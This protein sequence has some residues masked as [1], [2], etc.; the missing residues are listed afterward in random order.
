MTDQQPTSNVTVASLA[1][2]YQVSAGKPHFPLNT[3]RLVY[4][5]FMETIAVADPAIVEKRTQDILKL[6][7]LI[8]AL[9]DARSTHRAEEANFSLESEWNAIKPQLEAIYQVIDTPQVRELFAYVFSYVFPLQDTLLLSLYNDLAN[10]KKFSAQDIYTIFHIRSMD[11]IIYSNIV[12]ALLQRDVDATL[13]PADMQLSLNYKL[14]ALYQLNDLVDAIVYAKEDMESKNFS[15]F[16]LIKKAAEDPN[17]ARQMIISIAGAF[18]KRLHTFSLGEKTEVLLNDFGHQLIGVIGGGASADAG[19]TGVQQGELVQDTSGVDD[20]ADTSFADSGH[21]P[22]EQLLEHDA[23]A[24]HQDFSE[25]SDVTPVSDV[26]EVSLPQ[27]P[28]TQIPVSQS[29]PEPAIPELPATPPVPPVQ[30]QPVQLNVS[31]TPA[32]P[33][34]FEPVASQSLEQ[35]QQEVHISIPE[36]TAQSESP[37]VPQ[38]QQTQVF[39]GQATEEESQS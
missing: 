32:S 36:Q 28:V 21:N 12:G 7:P 11:S 24:L 22:V 14:N 9:L 4:L 19:Q 35:T 16:E 37:A 2:K 1:N 13:L 33:L 5:I 29:I 23:D 8:Q 38:A 6:I 34:S 27:T 26:P 15:P 20:P 25:A 31:Q 17:Q 39:S 18:E 3:L 30:P 10:E